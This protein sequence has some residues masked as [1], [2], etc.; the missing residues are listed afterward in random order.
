MI[1]RDVVSEV[2]ALREIAR[3]GGYSMVCDSC[4]VDRSTV[5]LHD[6]FELNQSSRGQSQMV[7]VGKFCGPCFENRSD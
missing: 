6:V 3:N 2:Q 7:K 4:G 1:E 5:V